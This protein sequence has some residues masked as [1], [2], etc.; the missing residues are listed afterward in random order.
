MSQLSNPGFQ[1]VSSTPRSLHS[2]YS[3]PLA[4]LPSPDLLSAHNHG[5]RYRPRSGRVV[6]GRWKDA[7][8]KVV[9]SS[10]RP[11][12]ETQAQHLG[13]HQ[14]PEDSLSYTARLRSRLRCALLAMFPP[15]RVT[16][17]AAAVR[18]RW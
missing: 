13:W 9:R 8:W 15:H 7:R 3:H 17:N 10:L 18:L 16:L 5:A 2:V 11:K 1:A 4:P 6:Q 12:F 14:G